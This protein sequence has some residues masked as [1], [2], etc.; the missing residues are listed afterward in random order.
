MSL[1]VLKKRIKDDNVDG[2]YAFFGDEEYTKAFYLKKMMSYA[3]ESPTPE[4]NLV[5]FNDETITASDLRDALDAPP[6][7][8]EHKVI[9]VNGIPF[10]NKQLITEL[11]D[12]CE[13]I[14]DG[15]ILI[16]S[17]R[18]GEIDYA[19]YQKKKDK[20][21]YVPLLDVISGVGLCVEFAKESGAK[22]YNWIGKHFSSRGIIA[23]KDAIEFL[24]SYCGN[25][26]TVLHSEID[27]LCS[28]CQGRNVTVRDVEFVCCPNAEYQIFD[29]ASSVAERKPARTRA[30]M[31]N[32]RFNGVA[33]EII[34]GTVA[35]SFCDMLYVK[36]AF[37]ENRSQSTTKSAVGMA[38]W[39]YRRTLASAQKIDM[40]SLQ[41]IVI[42][43]ND[44]DKH[45]KTFSG[46]PYTQLELLFCQINADEKT[47]P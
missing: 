39:L 14:P 38:D 18:P 15:V 30:I 43:C 40:Q 37:S 27:K 1:E 16:F 45:L 35:K 24:P 32:F 41:H 29:L 25:E 28:Y 34:M 6:F 4:F 19:A 42:A 36:T 22:L 17:F 23:D 5:T 11:C 21:A 20:G 26:M 46:D 7:M 47:K 8:T 12:I 2:V 44:T 10:S 3:E 33:P 31:Q 9:Y 13:D